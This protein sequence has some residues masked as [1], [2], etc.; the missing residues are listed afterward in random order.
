MRRYVASLLQHESLYDVSAAIIMITLQT[1]P[2]NR[3][4]LSSILRPVKDVNEYGRTR[5]IAASYV[6][7]TYHKPSKQNGRLS[8][9]FY[10]IS[11]GKLRRTLIV[12][13]LKT[14]WFMGRMG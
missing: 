1:L 9:S 6:C 3:K 10:A 5:G 4:Y 8:T 12:L 7:T 13:V 11:I 2:W 14:F